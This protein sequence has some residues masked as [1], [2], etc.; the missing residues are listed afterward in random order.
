MKKDFN[1]QESLRWNFT[2]VFMQCMKNHPDIGMILTQGTSE[3]ALQPTKET[4]P[5]LQLRRWFSYIMITLSYTSQC[6]SIWL[7]DWIFQNT[8]AW[9]NSYI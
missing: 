5:A 4:I 3:Q 1:P 2:N 9:S 6:P 7:R 8:D